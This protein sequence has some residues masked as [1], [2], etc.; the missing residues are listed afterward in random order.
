MKYNLPALWKAAVLG[1]CACLLLLGVWGAIARQKA[2]QRLALEAGQRVL[3]RLPAVKRGM[4]Q[5][6]AHAALGVTP[7][8]PHAASSNERFQKEGWPIGNNRLLVLVYQRELEF[9]E[10]SPARLVRTEII[11]L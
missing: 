1:S 6:E 10:Q 9:K 2:T 11:S 8:M 5:A 4:T 7:E 3:S